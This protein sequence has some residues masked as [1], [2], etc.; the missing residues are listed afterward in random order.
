MSTHELWELWW[1]V[2][3]SVALLGYGLS[4]VGLAPA[5]RAVW[6]TARIV[7]VGQPAHGAAKD[8][9]IPVTIAFQDPDSGREF[10]LPNAGRHG[11]GVEAAWVGRE[12]TVR[13]RRGRP[14]RFRVVLDP[15]DEKRGR[16]VPNCT[17]ALLL[18]GLVI[19]AA[20]ARGRPWALLGFG[21]LLT[22][23]MAS[24]AD[25]RAVRTRDALLS[26]AVAVPARVVAVT[27]DEYED[28][29]G[30]KIVNHAPVVTFTTREGVHVTVLS[31]DGIPDPGR[32][33][34]RH[35][36]IHY[37]PDDPTV[38]TPDLAAERRDS[39]RA[40]GWIVILVVVGIAAVVAGAIAL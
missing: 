27:K 5:Q 38:H 12:L 8:P 21:T 39:E 19:H 24:G 33:L 36:T 28:G 20:V 14:D 31:R 34:G 15:A 17:V 32:S 1:V 40:V 3:A 26:S 10:V 4:L 35:L 16:V 2:P 29:E 23:A 37:A 30:S 6:V 13:Y 18:I 25:L 9:G 11:R 7:E 22:V